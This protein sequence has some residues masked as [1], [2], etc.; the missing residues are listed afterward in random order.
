[1][2]RAL[3][4]L[5]L[6]TAFVL[7]SA[8]ITT[9][10]VNAELQGTPSCEINYYMAVTKFDPGIGVNYE[11]YGGY[12]TWASAECK[13][14]NYSPDCRPFP[15][16][17][18][19]QESEQLP[20]DVK[21][22][23]IRRLGCSPDQMTLSY[24]YQCEDET[25]K[26]ESKS[27]TCPFDCPSTTPSPTPTPFCYQGDCSYS[28]QREYELSHIHPSCAGGSVD[29][30][31]YPRTGCP[32]FG[33]YRY[34]WED[35]CCCNKAMS[36]PIV[37]DVAG[38]GFQLTDNLQGVNFDLNGVGIK[39]RLS[40]TA[41]DSDDAF[42]ALDRD[43]NGTIDNGKELFSLFTDQPPSDEPQGFLALAEFDKAV[44]G[45]NGDGKISIIDS[46]FLALRLWQDKNHNGISEAAE[47]HSLPE[48]GLAGIELDYKESKRTDEWGNQFR[49]RAKVK[50]VHGAQV[51]RWAW[52]V[53]LVT[54]GRPQ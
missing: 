43:S 50:D 9:R 24:A 54:G 19:I 16:V 6:L 21:C 5:F 35:N 33:T 3:T 11:S 26:T 41:A 1:M 27:L 15:G 12:R 4:F 2:K 45:G 22:T 36:D 32:D 8:S 38:D 49:Y 39:E 48:L 34:N 53:F 7:V 40:W 52:D 23:F 20:A 46:I 44:N 14:V 51:G 13:G 28:I 37:V 10:F 18:F 30:C 17:L 25:A 31:V 47:L 42:L 29:Y